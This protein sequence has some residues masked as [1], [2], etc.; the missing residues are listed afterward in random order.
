MAKAIFKGMR[1]AYVHARTV[2]KGVYAL[3]SW[4]RARG[5]RFA[6]RVIGE[7][8]SIAIGAAFGYFGKKYRGYGRVRLAV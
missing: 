6:A 4:K 5:N 8:T 3:Q 1:T 7:S 2:S